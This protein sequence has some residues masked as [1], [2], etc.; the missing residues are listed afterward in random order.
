M[1]SPLQINLGMSI[2]TLVGLL[3]L[4]G[5]WIVFAAILLDN[6]G[7][8][9]PGE[10]VL[11]TFGG[12]ARSGHLDPM[13][14]LAVATAAAL[15]GDSLAYWAGRLGGEWVR[16]RLPA[17]RGL[18]PRRRSVVLGKFVFGARMF[19]APLA[20]VGRMPYRRFILFDGLGTLVWAGVFI[21]L[22]YALGAHFG[23][24]QSALKTVAAVT[25]TGLAIGAAGYLTVRHLRG[26]LTLVPVRIRLR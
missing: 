9:I 14:G 6:A 5:Y 4:Y 11:L 2:E 23:A 18:A 15:A 24:I 17:G 19:L 26:N 22:G 8:P 3:A 7:L 16:R 13:L 10:L 21:G 20:G 12:M 1:V 25:L